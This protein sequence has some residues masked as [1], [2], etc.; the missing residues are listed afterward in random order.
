MSSR[1]L[2]RLSISTNALPAIW[3]KLSKNFFAKHLTFSENYVIIIIESER[4]TEHFYQ[5]YEHLGEVP[6]QGAEDYRRHQQT[7]VG[8]PQKLDCSATREDVEGARKSATNKVGRT[9]QRHQRLGSHRQG[10]R[11]VR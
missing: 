6:H 11:R 1:Y 2:I 4:E 7:S 9:H 8:I 5:L 10:N 3:A